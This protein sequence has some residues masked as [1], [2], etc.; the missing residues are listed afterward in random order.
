[1]PR[2]TLLA[3]FSAGLLMLAGPTRAATG[4]YELT[5]RN[6]QFQ[7]ATLKLPAGKRIKLVVKNEDAAPMEF[8]SYD[9]DRE[10]VI[11]GHSSGIVYIGPLDPDTYKIFDDFHRATTNGVIQVVAQQ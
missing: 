4:D 10:K 9:L 5:V 2:L 7:P 6:H 1:M 3:V 8:E 11:V